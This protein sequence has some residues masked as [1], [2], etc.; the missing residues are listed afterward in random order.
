MHSSLQDGCGDF[1]NAT[2]ES[3]WLAFIGETTMQ[4]TY[5]PDTMTFMILGDG[6]QI[7]LMMTTNYTTPIWSGLCDS[8]LVIKNPENYPQIINAVTAA[9]VSLQ[10]SLQA[11]VP[12][13]SS[14]TGC[15]FDWYVY[16]AGASGSAPVVAT[17][18]PYPAGM[19]STPN[20]ANPQNSYIL[21][22]NV[23]ITVKVQVSTQTNDEHSGIS[24]DSCDFVVSF[25]IVLLFLYCAL[26]WTDCSQLLDP[27]RPTVDNRRVRN[28]QRCHPFLPSL[29][30]QPVQNVRS[31]TQRRFHKLR[32]ESLAYFLFFRQATR[33]RACQIP[34]PFRSP[35]SSQLWRPT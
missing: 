29:L 2:A 25:H 17:V 26:L 27:T 32:T 18:T 7:H 35:P 20:P 21:S 23:S 33:V 1:T 31:V 3:Q 12:S 4:M 11:M 9:S 19:V 5:V 22:I 28:L 14:T 15:G 16:G 34:P 24:D 30:R 13:S 6:I 8:G 10:A